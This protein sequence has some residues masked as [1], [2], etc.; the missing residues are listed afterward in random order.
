MTNT[1]SLDEILK[2]RCV[3]SGISLN[4]LN[5]ISWLNKG[6]YIH[7]LTTAKYEFLVNRCIQNIFWR[8]FRCF[9]Q[10]LLIF[11]NVKKNQGFLLLFHQKWLFYYLWRFHS[12]IRNFWRGLLDQCYILWFACSICHQ[13]RSNRLLIRL[14]MRRYNFWHLKRY[15]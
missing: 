7:L 4:V 5:G 3:V 13:I 2:H 10:L 8:Y 11:S 15:V 9:W 12:H 1:F 14:E 6:F